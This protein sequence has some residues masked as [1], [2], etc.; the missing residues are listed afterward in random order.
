VYTAPVDLKF[1]EAME[2][3]ALRVHLGLYEDETAAR[4]HWHIP[5]AHYLE[6]W[7]DVRADD[8]TVTIIQPLIAPLYGGKSA[9]EVIAALSGAER[10]A[11]DLVRAYWS[12]PGAASGA[13]T[14]SSGAA[15]NAAAASGPPQG[16]RVRRRPVV[17]PAPGLQRLHPLGR[18]LQRRRARMPTAEPR[19]LR[20]RGRPRHHCRSTSSCERDVAVRSRLAQV[21]T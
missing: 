10:P 8:G 5:E 2:K 3:V 4:C 18:R 1:A 21:A 20:D 16:A 6:S 17:L 15:A 19:T 7:S 14:I 11:Y 12:S 13:G 9:H